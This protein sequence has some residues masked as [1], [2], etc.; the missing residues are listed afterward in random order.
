M[1]IFFGRMRSSPARFHSHSLGKTSRAPH[2]VRSRVSGE[3][4]A[5]SRSLQWKVRPDERSRG[6]TTRSG[7]QTVKFE[8]NK[9]SIRLHGKVTV[10]TYTQNSNGNC[11]LIGP[12][13]VCSACSEGIELESLQSGE[14]K[15]QCVAVC[16]PGSKW[17]LDDTIY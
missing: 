8:V 4:V 1:L 5:A 12:G 9:P 15:V 14:K 10:K 3:K 2:H 17:R 6:T 13:S 7:Q 11:L 16:C